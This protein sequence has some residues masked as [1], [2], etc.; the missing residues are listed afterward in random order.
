M[1]QKSFLY[2]RNPLG[3]EKLAEV[4]EGCL[5]W[6]CGEGGID[7]N[8]DGERGCQEESWWRQGLPGKERV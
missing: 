1:L 2:S 5:F 3:F 7:Q 8:L 6:L 4:D